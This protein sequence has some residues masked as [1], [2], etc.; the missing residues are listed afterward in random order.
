MLKLKPIEWETESKYKHYP[1]FRDGV[2]GTNEFLQFRFHVMSYG[3]PY[4]AGVSTNI[5]TTAES[6]YD[7]IGGSYHCFED[8]KQACELWYR[9][10]I[11]SFLLTE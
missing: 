9:K 11:E 8:A 2:A 7:C 6:S 1:Y 5:D 10:A 4:S 3:G